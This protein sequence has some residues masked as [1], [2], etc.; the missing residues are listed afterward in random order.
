LSQSNLKLI[1]RDKHVEVFATQISDRGSIPLV[2]TTTHATPIN[3]GLEGLY[4]NLIDQFYH[5]FTTYS[6]TINIKNLYKNP[7]GYFYVNKKING[8]VVKIST[9]TKDIFI[10]ISKKEQ[11]LK[12]GNMFDIDDLKKPKLAF[13]GG[14]KKQRGDT[15]EDVA[16]EEQAL[17]EFL[18]SRNKIKKTEIKSN[19]NTKSIKLAYKEFLD[20]KKNVEKVQVGTFKR[21]ITAHKYL[22]LFTKESE[23]IGMLDKKFF[24]DAQQYLAQL[25]ANVFKFKE[26]DGL[27]AMEILE[28]QKDK[29][30]PVLNNKTNNNHMIVYKN[31]FD[32]CISKDYLEIN[33]VVVKLLKEPKSEKVAF[34]MEDLRQLFDSKIAQEYKNI[35]KFGLYTG[36]R[37]QS[38]INLQFKDIKGGF[39][40]IEE[41]KTDSGRRR[42]PVHTEIIELCKNKNNQQYLFFEGVERKEE[43]SE[44]Q[45]QVARRIRKIIPD[46]R[47]TFHST[48][49]NFAQQLYDN[50]IPEMVIKL[51]I[52]HSTEDN[53]T[54][55]VYGQK[56]TKE[57]ILF[58]AIDSIN[59]NNFEPVE[60][61]NNLA[62]ARQMALEIL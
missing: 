47:K 62:L 46:T 50:K 31:F 44:L 24:F 32:F 16:A 48:R 61:I 17:R 41:D 52:G 29:K 9:R 34:E 39:I 36:M 3:K 28:I 4:K 20:H 37:I 60:K 18:A 33:P 54:F 14:Y 22:L 19:E 12:G 43:N 6:D 23:K 45:K 7:N 53:L 1:N 13:I 25:P 11:I 15:D 10:A 5:L 56:K 2:S 58:E 30:Y 51:L 55:T 59:Y 35:I 42:I 26:F 49:K 38:I 57:E 21:Y 27:N 8:K 40:Y